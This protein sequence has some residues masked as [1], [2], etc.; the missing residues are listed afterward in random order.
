MEASDVDVEPLRAR[1]FGEVPLPNMGGEVSSAL[2][3][4]GERDHLVGEDLSV[5]DGDEF[6]IAS[7][8]AGGLSDGIDSVSLRP[9]SGYGAGSRGSTIGGS[10]IPVGEANA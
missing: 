5:G 8:S 9:L 10:C 7:F 1:V 2:E 3:D 6:A 4:F